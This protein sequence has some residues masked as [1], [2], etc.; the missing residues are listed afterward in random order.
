MTDDILDEIRECIELVADAERQS[1]RRGEQDVHITL[2]GAHQVIA[3]LV[4]AAEAIEG[5]G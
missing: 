2:A 1:G 4:A 3:A 5:A